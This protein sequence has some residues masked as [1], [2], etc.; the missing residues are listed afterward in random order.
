MS[1]ALHSDPAKLALGAGEGA[2]VRSGASEPAQATST[3]STPTTTKTTTKSPA[4]ANVSSEPTHSGA[5][6]GLLVTAAACASGVEKASR[7][8]G[9]ETGA[10]EPA[11]TSQ[12]VKAPQRSDKTLGS[13][14]TPIVNTAAM[15]A[16]SSVS[17]ISSGNTNTKTKATGKLRVKCSSGYRGVNYERNRKAW[18]ASIYVNDKQE[19][20]GYFG[21]EVAAAVA[22][23]RAALV[24]RGSR[25]NFPESDVGQN[26]EEDWAQT[27]GL[28]RVRAAAR[29]LQQG[30]GGPGNKG[31][32]SSSKVPKR[33]RK[34]KSRAKSQQALPSQPKTKSKRIAR[35]ASAAES[36]P[37]VLGSPGSV[38]SG[39]SASGSVDASIGTA[40]SPFFPRPMAPLT[41]PG[42]G[43]FHPGVL[44]PFGGGG[45]G[46]DHHAGNTAATATSPHG[47]ARTRGGGVPGMDFPH[48]F[49]QFIHPSRLASQ[50]SS[51]LGR[52]TEHGATAR[53]GGPSSSLVMSQGGAA[54]NHSSAPSRTAHTFGDS[55]AFDRLNNNSNNNNSSRQTE[56]KR[57]QF[58]AGISIG[59][60]RTSMASAGV[61]FPNDAQ[62]QQLQQLQQ[63]Q[64]RMPAGNTL[65][66]A[67]A[68]AAA[69]ES[70]GSIPSASSSAVGSPSSAL[71]SERQPRDTSSCLPSGHGSRAPPNFSRMHLEESAMDNHRQHDH[72]NAAQ[73]QAAAAAAAVQRATYAEM[74]GGYPPMHMSLPPPFGYGP[75]TPGSPIMMVPVPVPVPLHSF[76]SPQ[77][78]AMMPYAHHNVGGQQ[79]QHQ[80]RGGSGD[81]GGGGHHPAHSWT[82]STGNTWV[83]VAGPDMGGSMPAAMMRPE[84][85]LL[86]SPSTLA[87]ISL[88]G[89]PLQRRQHHHRPTASAEEP[90]Q[91]QHQ[92]QQLLSPGGASASFASSVAQ[93]PS[94]IGG[95]AFMATGASAAAAP[96]DQSTPRAA[97]SVQRPTLEHV[98]PKQ[99]DH[100]PTLVGSFTYGD[101]VVGEQQ[102]Q[103]QH[104][105]I[106]RQDAAKSPVSTSDSVNGTGTASDSSS[107]TSESSSRSQRRLNSSGA[108]F[109]PSRASAPA[110]Q[111]L[112]IDSALRAWVVD[113]MNRKE[114]NAEM[115]SACAARPIPPSA[116]QAWIDDAE[117][118]TSTQVVFGCLGDWFKLASR[119]PNVALRHHI[120]HC[121]ALLGVSQAYIARKISTHRSTM[122]EWLSGKRSRWAADTGQG[123]VEWLVAN[124]LAQDNVDMQLAGILL[125]LDARADGVDVSE[126]KHLIQGWSR[127][128]IK[129]V[130]AFCGWPLAAVAAASP[131]EGPNNFNNKND[132]DMRP[133]VTF[134]AGS[135]SPGVGGVSATAAATSHLS[136][137]STSTQ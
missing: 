19:H 18:R 88:P 86:W 64:Q 99:R 28:R 71:M 25:V 29:G 122:S 68:A 134:G 89:P 48:Y 115:V 40:G 90:S 107:A 133:S 100:Q 85:P 63:Q 39:S 46:S 13:G 79:Q 26:T 56:A 129:Q 101:E 131:S 16:A 61:S 81:G 119:R 9:G 105:G 51:F 22:Y 116:L 132:T 109:P 43:G 74:A 94:P 104:G 130:F 44:S 34:R 70:A 41:S 27:A 98:S 127:G 67:A 57:Q 114:A 58:P 103:Q 35:G 125:A 106:M 4:A 47:F 1:G 72:A 76:S 30:Q 62:Q 83:R 113:I 91:Q 69:A 60:R 8:R 80:Q 117:A 110:P 112:T 102:Q 38:A 65:A 53:I 45:A 84:A 96:R 124:L 36:V 121:I 108:S 136:I 24:L 54:E 12:S 7:S 42:G 32:S 33:T 82:D 21:T 31:D 17:S 73:A 50:S 120:R 66:T 2:G 3:R 14:S 137:S 15:S 55:G 49:P 111:L 37:G 77:M 128:F 97:V 52:P 87:S 5:Q 59:A 11:A 93:V 95:S 75:S 92:Q 78:H 123:C 118:A 126:S 23:D 6:L 135:M 10:A 20:L